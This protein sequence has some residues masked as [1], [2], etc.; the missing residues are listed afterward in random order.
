MKHVIITVMII[1]ST[2]LMAIQLPVYLQWRSSNSFTFYD[3]RE[4]ETSRLKQVY[5]ITTGIDTLFSNGISTRLELSN[6]DELLDSQILIRNAVIGYNNRRFSFQAAMQDFGYG[7]TFHLYN[8]NNDDA[9]FNENVLLNNRWY[10]IHSGFNF[11]KSFFGGGIG[12]N[13]LN[14]LLCETNFKNESDMAVVNIYSHYTLRDSY[15]S[16][17]AFDVGLE[18]KYGLDWFGLH[19][20]FNYHYL[21]ESTHLP[22]IKSWH[23]INEMNLSISHNARL[24]LSSDLQTKTEE[25]KIYHLYEGCLDYSEGRFQGYMGIRRQNI[26]SNEALTTFLDLNYA[27]RKK[28]SVGIVFDLVK[29]INE[30]SYIKFG[31]QTNY[32]L[33]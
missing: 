6:K 29:I 1:C 16:V 27:I 19:S 22:D 33:D 13:E 20:G 2:H 30:D 5:R 21:P 31:I 26:L 25:S 4:L 15:Y 17:M 11:G 12:S 23:L 7:N 14:W 8:R 10:G 32:L 3:L 24:I 9:F 28:L 18:L